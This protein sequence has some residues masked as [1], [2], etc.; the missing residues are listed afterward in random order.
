MPAPG[1]SVPNPKRSIPV[2]LLNLSEDDSFGP[3]AED[4]QI[5]GGTRAIRSPIMELNAA[6]SQEGRLR[7]PLGS[8]A[9]TPELFDLN[10][11][12][13]GQ[14][15]GLDPRPVSRGVIGSARKCKSSASILDEGPESV[16][17]SNLSSLQGGAGSES[18]KKGAW[19]SV[20]ASEVRVQSP[21][22]RPTSTPAYGSAMSGLFGG[23]LSLG[24]GGQEGSLPDSALLS[25]SGS[26]LSGAV[27]GRDRDYSFGS[28]LG[29]APTA[30]GG[31][32]SSVDAFVASQQRTPSA[33][34][35]SM[36][37]YARPDSALLPSRG[38]SRGAGS[39]FADNSLA[40]PLGLAPIKTDAWP[41]AAAGMS[42]EQEIRNSLPLTGTVSAPPLLNMYSYG[43]DSINNT[44]AFGTS[45]G[46]TGR[47]E[48]LKSRYDSRIPEPEPL[49][50]LRI[51]QQSRTPPPV[52]ALLAPAAPQLAAASAPAQGPDPESVEG[53]V[54]RSC[55]DI[56]AG[57][58]E[59][60]LKAVELAN[61]L[62]ARGTRIHIPS[63]NLCVSPS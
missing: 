22:G 52:E 4:T 59:H 36:G 34:L 21:I 54:L 31:A 8:T 1:M 61:T 60:S 11:E 30:E 38:N 62:R 40:E 10:G 17:T 51:S 12:N 45:V 48:P 7:I 29:L 56:L 58:A 32:R 23:A 37:L 2:N 41:P 26:A 47:F 57:A 9:R 20:L 27:R 53:T 6:A 28:L 16:G 24:A 15:F 49:D 46:P 44:S 55:R 19:D 33:P 14:N 42:R 5:L 13:S 63:M 3:F 25:D 43:Y 35:D 18:S 50:G 39:I